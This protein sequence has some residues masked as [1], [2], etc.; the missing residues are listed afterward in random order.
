[1]SMQD[2]KEHGVF[3]WNELM[4]NDMPAAK[5]F[6]RE[7]LGWVTEDRGVYYYD[8][9]HHHH[10]FQHSKAKKLIVVPCILE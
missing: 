5:K 8:H 4:T 1:M 3:S 2:M 10:H 9:H 7:A 6:Y